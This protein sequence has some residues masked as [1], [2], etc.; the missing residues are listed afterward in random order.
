MINT[1]DCKLYYDSNVG[2]YLIE[3]RGNFKDQI[4]KVSYACG[5]VITN[6]LGVIAVS[7]KNLQ[8]L[9]RDVPEIVFVDFRDMF[10]LQD[11]SPSSTDNIASI[12]INPYLQLT[13]RGV[14][15]GIVDTGIDYLNQE[16]MR[17]DGTSRIFSIWD[18]TIE[19]NTNDSLYI[20]D[21]YSNQQINNAINL[22]KNQGDPYSI[23]PSKDNI[24]H[25]TKAAGIMG[26][27]GYSIEFQGIAN[28]SDF[29]VV[30]LFPSSNFKKTL[31]A[32]G[33]DNV[34]VYNQS[35]IVAGLE[36]LKRV[37][38]ESRKPMVI[39]L[40]VGSSEGA[41]D[42]TNL[43]SRYVSSL[44]SIR[45]ICLVIGVGNEGASQGHA[46]GNIRNLGDRE[47]I[48]IRIP[49]EITSFGFKVWVQKPNR[50]SINIISPT[51]EDS[52]L[53]ESKTNKTQQVKYVFLNTDMTVT[54]YTPENF[55]GHEVIDIVFIS[56]KPGIWIIQLVGEYITNG[57]YDIWLTP[58][59]TLPEGTEFIEPDP[60]NTLTIP[61][62]ALNVA[63]IGYFGSDNA[64]LAASG[65]GFNTN[66]L[67]NPD[68]ATLGINILTTQ[69]LGG[70]TTLSGSSAATAVVAGACA[71]LLQ[72]GII[73]RNDPTMYSK[74]IISYLMYGAFRSELF[75]YPSREIG[76]GNFDLLGTFNVISRAYRNE[77]RIEKIDYTIGKN[78]FQSCDNDQFIEYYS[79][80]LFIRIPRRNME[81]FR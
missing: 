80:N 69:P 34:P 40:G 50:A 63:T 17:E 75:K 44:G 47:S 39:Y 74:K 26:A 16:F 70:I 30:K 22:Y 66:G 29:V 20:G 56:I 35:E 37:S 38:I 53:I 31:E 62:T 41:H 32:N 3:Y 48:E 13:G 68:I 51:G 21:T 81:E 15:I 57:R 19:N 52:K 46:S 77:N 14:L 79:N 5:D 36:Y 78:N 54:Y 72:W 23:V 9:R 1:R 55:T 43:I 33:I 60:L 4:D 76:Y 73:N 59:G 12:K 61:S 58:K 2:N 71:L 45:G 65:K 28:D 8:Q 11:I 27:R 49:K 6:S 7:D 42:G 10:V 64:I 67:V 25:G 18:Q 24:G